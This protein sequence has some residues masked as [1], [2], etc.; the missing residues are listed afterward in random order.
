MNQRKVEYIEGVPHW[1]CNKCDELKPETAY[2]MDRTGQRLFNRKPICKVCQNI[3][4]LD[5]LH[6]NPIKAKE[7]NRRKYEKLKNRK[8]SI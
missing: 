1:E 4:N 3:K 2:S 5:Y 8:H 6:R 7:F